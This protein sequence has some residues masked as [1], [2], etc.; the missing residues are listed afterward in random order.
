MGGW[1]GSNLSLRPIKSDGEDYC[2]PR[3]V[4]PRH[5][6]PGGERVT[7]SMITGMRRGMKDGK[8]GATSR[9]QFCQPPMHAQASIGMCDY[10][11]VKFTSTS[12]APGLRIPQRGEVSFAVIVVRRE[13]RG[14]HMARIAANRLHAVEIKGLPIE[15]VVS[16][17]FL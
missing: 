2:N 17:T 10:V 12:V 5:Q 3:S 14:R 1:A 9:Q 15:N 8:D 13:W 6:S 16:Q 11:G 7:S 4:R